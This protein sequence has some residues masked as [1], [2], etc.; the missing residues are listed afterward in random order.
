VR[1]SF[2]RRGL[3]L[4]FLAGLLAGC[5]LGTRDGDG[6]SAGAAPP[7]PQAGAAPA[8]ALPGVPVSDSNATDPSLD[9]MLSPLHDVEIFARVEGEVTA[10]FAEEG[11]RVRAG[12]RLAQI[13]DRERRALLAERDAAAARAESAWGRAQRLR[14]EDVISEEQFIAARS[15]WEIA[16]AQRDRASIEWQ[17]CAV[18]APFA[19]LVA[20]RRVQAGQTVKVGDLLFRISDP[21][22]LRAELLLPE[23]RLG[24]V[25]AG[26]PV[27]LVPVGGG[28][29]VRARVTRV[30]PLV[31]PASGT[32]RVVIDFD[33]RAAALHGGVSVRVVFEDAKRGVP[34]SPVRPARR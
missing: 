16:R 7:D 28:G 25:A 5:D 26:Q 21:D 23:S 24:T 18:K 19:G 33:N 8:G 1:H 27:R 31:D 12:A 9:T 15:E 32:F 14:D 30:N 17:R 20:L 11:Q 29:A 4:L 6:S 34:D 3:A 13:D 2:F 10:L 22:T